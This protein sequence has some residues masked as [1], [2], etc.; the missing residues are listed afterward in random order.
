MTLPPRP[1]VLSRLRP[2][3]DVASAREVV[4]QF[5]PNW[6]TVTMGTGIV[7]LDI[8][9]VPADIP[10]RLAVAETLWLA[11]GSLWLV[12]ALL[13]LGRLAAFPET[14]RPML[15]HPVQ[16]MFLGAIPMGLIPVVNGCLLFGADW[17]GGAAPDVALAL[18]W[19]DVGLAVGVALVVPYVMLTRQDHAADGITPIW[20]LPIVGPEVTAA[21]GGLLAPHIAPAAAEGVVAVSYAL[22]AVSV[23]LAFSIVTIVFLR[24]A[25]HKLPPADLAASFWLILGPM[26]TGSLGLLTLGQAAPQVFVD[27]PLLEAALTARGVGLLGGA[28]LWGT[29]CWWL[30]MALP[31]TLRYLRRGLSFNLGWW[32]FTFP[33]G[34]FTAAGLWLARLTGF[35]PLAWTAMALTALLAAIWGIVAAHTLRGMWHGSLFRAPCLLSPAGPKPRRPPSL[36]SADPIGALSPN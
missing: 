18:W 30:L 9:A 6:F 13:F 2:L 22:W 8:A 10:G 28:L 32:G 7:A 20:L 36:P 5:T 31:V 24:Y 26:G 25:L 4:R 3:T 33:L 15:H 12:F 11:G 14:I 1:T 17:M 35:V 23:P 16:S 21:S 29:G 34:V 27:P 19:L